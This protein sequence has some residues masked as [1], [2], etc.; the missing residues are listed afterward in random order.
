VAYLAIYDGY[1]KVAVSDGSVVER[2]RLPR[3]SMGFAITPDGAT[4]IA[5][6]GTA[7]AFGPDERLLLVDVR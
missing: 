5:T 3:W 4:L 6:S 7:Q 1:L 2:V